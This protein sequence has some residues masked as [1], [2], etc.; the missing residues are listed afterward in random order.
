M[1]FTHTNLDD[2]LLPDAQTIHELFMEDELLSVTPEI[3]ES[4]IDAYEA[5]EE[6]A[7]KASEFLTHA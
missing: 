7:A 1:T 4:P 5:Y 6:V 3:Q 2:Y